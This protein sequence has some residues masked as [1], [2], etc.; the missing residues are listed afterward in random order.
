MS[1]CIIS[2]EEKD[3]LCMTEE[4]VKSFNPKSPF[5]AYQLRRFEKQKFSL[6]PQNYQKLKILVSCSALREKNDL[7]RNIELIGKTLNS[8]TSLNS[9]ASLTSFEFEFTVIN[10]DPSIKTTDEIVNIFYKN[11][12]KKLSFQ[13]QIYNFSSKR[14]HEIRF[15]T[16]LEETKTDFDSIFFM[17]CNLPN[18][19]FVNSNNVNMVYEKIRDDTKLFFTENNPELETNNS[20]QLHSYLSKYPWE[21]NKHIWEPVKFIGETFNQKF[22]VVETNK[23]VFTHNDTVEHSIFY[24]VKN[25]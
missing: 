16:F 1:L 22:K 24:F 21:R 23:K 18:W 3:F 15:T 19:L 13:N 25:V 8:L 2:Q 9:S 17:G 11:L 5:E 12:E 10:Y 20:G 7:Y 4:E 6:N 14:C